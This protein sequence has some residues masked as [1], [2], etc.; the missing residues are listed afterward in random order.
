MESPVKD[1]A[2]EASGGH[3][4]RRPSARATAAGGALH[5]LRTRPASRR[6][7]LSLLAFVRSEIRAREIW[8]VFIAALVGAGAGLL[9]LAVGALAHLAQSWLYGIDFDER[10]SAIYRLPPDKIVILP[11]GGLLLG[12][13][14]WAWVQ[15]RP[16]TPVDPVEAN[17]LHGGRMSARDSLL[18]GVQSVISNG[19]GSLGRPGGRLCPARRGA[20]LA[21]RRRASTCG[22]AT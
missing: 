8:L 17:A 4:D 20:G 3:S 21:H 6:F 15:R 13:V 2:P 12:A 10:L 19:F 14:T 22:A 1:G 9:T 11:L 16:K 18:V 7:L 5:A